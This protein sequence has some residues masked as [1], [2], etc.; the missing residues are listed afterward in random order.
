LKWQVDYSKN[1]KE[2]PVHANVVK[3]WSIRKT[4]MRG[5]LNVR[6]QA[7]KEIKREKRK[8]TQTKQ[9]MT[10]IMLLLLETRLLLSISMQ[11]CLSQA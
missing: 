1:G 8:T 10:L 2:G 6:A 7:N 4:S 9:K 3:M 5:N 11:K